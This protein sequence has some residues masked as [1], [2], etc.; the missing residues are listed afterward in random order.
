MTPA[1]R[2]MSYNWDQRHLRVTFSQTSYGDYLKSG[3]HLDDPLPENQ[4]KAFRDRFGTLI[5]HEGNES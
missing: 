5:I 1:C 3:E 4:A 2:V